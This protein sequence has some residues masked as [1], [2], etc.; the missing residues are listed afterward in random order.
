[1]PN[2]SVTRTIQSVP[3]PPPSTTFCSNIAAFRLL[4]LQAAT[5]YVALHDEAYSAWSGELGRGYTDKAEPDS[6]LLHTALD[7]TKTEMRSTLVTVDQYRKEAQ[8]LVEK[9]IRVIEAK[10]PKPR[11][12]MPKAGQ[13]PTSVS[14]WTEED[15]KAVEAI[16]ERYWGRLSEDE[17]RRRKALL[18][19]RRTEDEAVEQRYGRRGR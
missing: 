2:R 6:A 8:A 3:V 7:E 15:V 10:S 19:Q 13:V 9:M 5:A 11:E 14:Q 4:L 17:R 12:Q 18:R 16:E 1:M